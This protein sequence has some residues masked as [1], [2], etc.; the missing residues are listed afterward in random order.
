MKK[1]KPFDALHVWRLKDLFV[2]IE[3]ICEEIA[4]IRIEKGDVFTDEATIKSLELKDLAKNELQK[5][6]TKAFLGGKLK[7]RK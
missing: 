1:E 6:C 3:Y 7:W 2:R 4:K 5:E